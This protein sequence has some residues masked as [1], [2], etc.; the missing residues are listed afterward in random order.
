M[1]NALKI[2]LYPTKAQQDSLNR[3]FGCARWVW[4]EALAETQRLYKE[5]GKGLNRY[6]MVNRLIK[7]KAENTWLAEDGV[8]QSLQQSVMSL[9]TAFGN[10]FEKRAGFPNFKKKEGR[11]SL[12]FPQRVKCTETHI[13]LP[14]MTAIKVRGYDST[15]LLGPLKTVT[16][17]RDPDGKFYASLLTDDGQPDPEPVMPVGGTFLGIDVGLTDFAVT[18]TGSHFN[19]PRHLK[20]YEKN[21]KRKQRNL[22]R[23][24][25]GSKSRQKAKKLVANCHARIANV[26]TDYLHKLSRRL[27]TESQGIAVEDLNVKGMMRNDSLAKAIGDAGWGTFNRMLEYKCKRAGKF[28]VKV[29]RFYPSSKTCSECLYRRDSMP[30]TVRTWTCDD[31]G[32]VHDR[33]EN[34]ARN[35]SHEAVRMLR[36]GLVTVPGMGTAAVG[37]TVRRKLGRKVSTTRVPVKTEVLACVTS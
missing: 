1:H 30:L 3:Q 21:L 25:K 32:V 13:S 35:I 18:S 5:T 26:R 11:Q 27:V 23:R 16:V 9:A 31:C 15:R 7:L 20:K 10:F 6:D 2:R 33:D 24:Q 28:F 4:N 14:K 8:A 37:G 29:D 22:S 12:Q 19:N 36:A 34:A 17:S